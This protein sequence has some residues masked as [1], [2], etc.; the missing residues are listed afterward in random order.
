MRGGGRHDRAIAASVALAIATALQ[1][2]PPAAG[3]APDELIAAMARAGVAKIAIAA[4]P[5]YAYVLPSGEPQGYM[6]D[7]SSEVMKALGV[8]KLAATV[9]T[10]DAMIPGLQ[11]RQ[12]DFVP[13]GLNIT[14]ARCQVV[15]FSAP[16]TAQQDALYVKPGNPKALAGYASVASSS[17][18]R[19]AVLTGSSLEAFARK[20]AIPQ[21]QL[22]VVPDTQAGIAAVTGDRAD[23]FAVGQF[24]IPDPARKGVEVVV[25]KASPLVGVGIVFR[26]ENMQARDAFDREL[27]VLRSSGALKRLYAEKYGFSN[28]DVLAKVTK[29]SDLA[30]GC[31]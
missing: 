7:V 10:W 26:K 20:E 2:T 22:I 15:L 19:L 6:V 14:S 5:P 25:D 4:V 11:A 1:L 21:A 17:D 8:P 30:P 23:A 18:A 27:D 3:A 29:V 24:S 16:V 28:W 12:Y 31:N 13:A 9:T